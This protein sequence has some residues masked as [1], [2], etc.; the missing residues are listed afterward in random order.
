MIFSSFSISL[1]SSVSVFATP[2]SLSV[3]IIPP[4]LFVMIFSSF[5][6][7]L[8]SSV[9]V[10]ATSSSVSVIITP[11][12][13]IIISS[14]APP[15][16]PS[17]QRH[18]VSILLL[19]AFP[20]LAKPVPLHP[21]SEILRWSTSFSASPSRPLLFDSLKLFCPTILFCLAKGLLRTARVAR[22]PPREVVV[23]ASALPVARSLLLWLWIFLLAFLA[24]REPMKDGVATIRC[25][26]WS[27]FLSCAQ[28]QVTSLSCGCFCSSHCLFESSFLRLSS[29][30]TWSRALLIVTVLLTLTFITRSS[31]RHQV[32]MNTPVSVGAGTPLEVTTRLA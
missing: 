6:I 28:W 14:T 30:V 11:S 1:C 20:A 29:F 17:P 5:S 10:F 2:S 7:S 21:V 3:L 32:Q 18:H 16:T 12:I 9:S 13:L 26:P 15:I 22:F 19:P 4:S 27:S 24:D 8:C 23:S 31:S 25:C